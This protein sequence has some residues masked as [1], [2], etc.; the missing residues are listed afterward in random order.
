[1]NLTRKT[2]FLEGWSWFRFN[3]LGLGLGTNLI[4]YTSVV[5]VLKP[6]VRKFCGLIPTFVEVTG[7]KL[8]GGPFWS[9]PLLSRVNGRSV[10][11]LWTLAHFTSASFSKF[12]SVT[13]LC[14]CC[15]IFMLHSLVMFCYVNF[16]LFSCGTFFILHSFHVALF[17]YYNHLMFCYFFH[18]SYFLCAALF[19][20]LLF[21][22]CTLFMLYFFCG[23]LL[24]CCT[25][26]MLEF[27][28][29][30]HFPCFSISKLHFFRVVQF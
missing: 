26:A 7:E 16:T 18:F 3:N 2:A 21:S 10:I 23:A 1:M 11:H 19:Y 25:F 29:V 28:R 9:L 22:R 4:F 24:P 14:L 6:N 30:V 12:H 8:V 27:F 13:I 17:S 20:V 15:T 5:K